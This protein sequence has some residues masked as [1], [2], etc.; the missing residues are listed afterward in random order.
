VT[1]QVTRIVGGVAGGRRLR[2]PKT[3]TRPTSDRAREALFNTLAGLIELDGARV[4]DLYA[5]SGALGLEALSR[6]AEVAV[7][8]ESDAEAARAIVANVTG[9]GLTGADVVRTTVERH[10]A[11]PPAEPFDV[12][13]ADPP[14]ALAE[15]DLAGAL[16]RLAGAD[17]VRSGGVVVV[18]RS[19][20][21]SE[22]EWPETL[23]PVKHKRY[24]D[25]ALWYRRKI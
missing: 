17:W 22:P 4:L 1:T 13:F 9:L 8:V 19:V 25:T 16:G 20:R 14:Y 21:S 7:L 3:G 2:V 11:S 18:E 12:V 15:P 23:R 6:G 24:G 5:G 10:L